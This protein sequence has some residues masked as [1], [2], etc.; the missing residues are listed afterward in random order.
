[1]HPFRV[2]GLT[3][4]MVKGDGDAIGA[5]VQL[6]CRETTVPRQGLSNDTHNL[7]TGLADGTLVLVVEFGKV[8]ATLAPRTTAVV[9]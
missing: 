3:A 7:V 5:G 6:A 9:R 2:D 8:H 1:M 4:D